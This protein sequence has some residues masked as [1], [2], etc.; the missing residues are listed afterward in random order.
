VS[1]AD[2]PACAHPSA[3]HDG[4]HAVF[5]RRWLLAMAQR[6]AP[7]PADGHAVHSTLPGRAEARLMNTGLTSMRYMMM[8]KGG[9]EYEAGLP[10]PQS[11][12]EAMAK[13]V[14]E[15]TRDGTLVDTGGLSPSSQGM[16]IRLANGKRS[17][18]DG[19]FA[20]A[21]EV[22]GGYAIVEAR[23]KYEALALAQ[24]VV[25]LHADAGIRDLEMEIRPLASCSP[26]SQ[27]QAAA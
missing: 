3:R 20:E 27:A 8:I 11:L 23:S 16:R 18:I 14:D 25:D 15:M 4:R 19:P 9:T 22:I 24:R 26:P 5:G 17:V 2:T 13:L 10:P 21:K 12:L 1:A 7:S 6:N